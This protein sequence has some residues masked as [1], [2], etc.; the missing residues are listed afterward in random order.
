MIIWMT[1]FF[2]A[3]GFAVVTAM[4]ADNRGRSYG[5]WLCIG[6]LFGAFGLIAV[7]VIN[8]VTSETGEESLSYGY[9][10]ASKSCPFCAELIKRAAIKCKH[11]GSAIELSSDDV[12]PHSD[13]AGL[14]TPTVGHGWTVR[15]PS[16]GTDIL[17]LHKGLTALGMPFMGIDGGTIITGPFRNER[18]A[19]D[20]VVRI[21]DSLSITGST[22]WMPQPVA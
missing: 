8:P 15:V 10:S 18:I 13:N 6:F 1:L 16:K 22:Y 20:V 2:S 9:Q 5:G 17:E 21:R 14:T 19:K 11:C 4:A 3:V 7:L 12:G